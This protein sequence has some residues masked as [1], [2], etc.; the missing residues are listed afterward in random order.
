MGVGRFKNSVMTSDKLEMR[1]SP[2]F[3]DVAANATKLATDGSGGPGYAPKELRKTA[4]SRNKH[5]DDVRGTG[6][7]KS[8]LSNNHCANCSVETEV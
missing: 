7:P 5:W 1:K 3:L 8:V 2:N 4:C 6:Y